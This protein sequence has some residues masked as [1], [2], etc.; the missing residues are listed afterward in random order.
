MLYTI[1]EGGDGVQVAWYSNPPFSGSGS[2][3]APTNVGAVPEAS[4]WA[5]LIVGFAGIGFMA[6]RRRPTITAHCNT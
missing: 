6:Y 5:M 4:T 3:T 1:P 2:Y